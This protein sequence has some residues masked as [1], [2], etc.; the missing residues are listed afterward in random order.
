MGDYTNNYQIKRN[1]YIYTHLM[2]I[3]TAKNKPKKSENA[4]L[5]G[6]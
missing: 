2:R 5:F 6:I 3:H 4:G 1:I